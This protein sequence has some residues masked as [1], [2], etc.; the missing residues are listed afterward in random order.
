M[1]LTNSC[2]LCG[3]P[4]TPDES[5]SRDHVV[6]TVLL[7]K[8]PP[9]VRGYDYAGWLLTHSH[10]NNHF[11]DETFFNSALYLVQYSRSGNTQD[12]YQ[13]VNL[14]NVTV[15]PFTA[16]QIPK[17]ID[18]DFKRFKFIDTRKIAIEE[19]KNPEFYADKSKCNLLQMAMYAAMT[20]MAKSSAALLVKRELKKVP[21]C[22][23]IFATPFDVSDGSN[24]SSIFGET[25]PFGPNTKAVL[26]EICPDEWLVSYQHQNLLILFLFVFHHSDVNLHKVFNFPESE[27][28]KYSGSSLNELLTNQWQVS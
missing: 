23:R 7:G 11:S 13:N 19:L 4:I 26:E 8:Q 21:Q 16:T 10:C 18:R 17:F 9:K 24:L 2:Y 28:H 25:T 12:T 1:I 27:I 22:W 15:L 5:S 3:K 6:P 20:V 14:P